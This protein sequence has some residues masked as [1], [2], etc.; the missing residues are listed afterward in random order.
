[1][2]LINK[3]YYIIYQSLIQIFIQSLSSLPDMHVYKMHSNFVN[4]ERTNDINE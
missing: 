1:M 3:N 2:S 4:N